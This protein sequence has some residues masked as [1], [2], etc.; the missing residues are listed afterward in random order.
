[1]LSFSGGFRSGRGGGVNGGRSIRDSSQ[2]DSESGAVG[3][4]K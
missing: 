1:M 3:S 4:E 2:L